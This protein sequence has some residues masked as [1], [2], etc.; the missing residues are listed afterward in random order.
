MIKRIDQIK[1]FGI[2]K[3]FNW[4]VIPD[5]EEFKEKNIIYGWNYSG[6]TTLSR[7]FTSLRDKTISFNPKLG[8]F[9]LTCDTGTFDNANLSSFPYD[10]LVFNA[11]YIK[12]NLRWE[13]DEH[14]QAIYFEVGDNAKISTEIERIKK[15]IDEINGT[16]TLKG[17]KEKYQ[18][19]IDEFNNFEL[20]FTQEASRIKNEA[21]SS[22]IEFNKGHLKRIKEKTLDDLESFIIS[23]KEELAVLSKTIK[24]EEPKPQLEDVAFETKINKIVD[25]SNEILKRI[26]SKESVIGILDKNLAAFNWAKSGVAL[27]EKNDNC[28]FCGNKITDK[29]FAHL[30]EYFENE[31]SR[32]K[33]DIFFLFKL[34]SEEENTIE[35]LNIPTSVNDL[36]DGFQEKFKKQKEK[37]EKE[38]AKY[39]AQLKN[40]SA[41]L[42][43]K[44]TNK[45]YTSINESFEV[46]RFQPLLNEINLLNKLIKEN[47]QF[48]ED[49]DQ[50]I[51]S[52]R[53]RYKNHL[54]ALFLKQSKYLSKQSQ[55]DKALEKIKTLDEQVETYNSNIDRL[56]SLKESDSE[57]CAQFN[58]FVQS[59]L[60]RDDIEIKLN[61]TTKKFNLMRGSDLAQNMRRYM[62][63]ILLP[64]WDRLISAN[65]GQY[66][67]QKL[68]SG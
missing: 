52:E 46:E 54:V 17:K 25:S 50:T 40:I 3:N 26:P 19:A 59:F 55:Y 49:F 35:Q 36:N 7:I 8:T 51:T 67:R 22:L 38:I 18:A 12:D 4:G 33:E 58:S 56:T 20:L 53:D 16:T 62:W 14:I 10:V 6:K 24:I 11:E 23:S 29:R 63:V 43:K 44:A 37:I 2:F 27:H 42:N 65:R 9:K 34:I 66:F 13:F 31:S 32:L 30:V 28:I 47:N 60:S 68:T 15:L 45:I 48:T 5:M 21:F 61:S 1:E 39:K 57:G 64:F 41:A